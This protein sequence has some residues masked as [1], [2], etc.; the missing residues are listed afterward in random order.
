MHFLPSSIYKE[1]PGSAKK[2]LSMSVLLSTSTVNLI[3][4]SLKWASFRAGESDVPR[5]FIS[6]F[7][8]DLTAKSFKET[9]IMVQAIK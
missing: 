4:L 3:L 9:I 1:I 2:Y 5:F 7:S 8:I 6:P